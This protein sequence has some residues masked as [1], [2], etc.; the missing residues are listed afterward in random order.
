MSPRRRSGAWLRTDGY[1]EALA[2]A[3]LP[4]DEDLVV[5]VE[6]FHWQDGTPH[7]HTQPTRTERPSPGGTSVRV[8]SVLGAPSRRRSGSRSAQSTRCLRPSHVWAT[9][10]T[11]RNAPLTTCW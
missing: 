9:T 5:P 6:T 2:A 11:A 7:P 4:F 1:R 10:T 3:G 8:V